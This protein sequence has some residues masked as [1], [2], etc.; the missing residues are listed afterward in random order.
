M[1]PAFL[2]NRGTF[3]QIFTEVGEILNSAH[4]LMQMCGCFFSLGLYCYLFCN[5]FRRRMSTSRSLGMDAIVP[6]MLCSYMDMRLWI[7][8]YPWI[9]TENLWIWIWIW[10]GNFISTATLCILRATARTSATSYRKF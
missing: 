10:V 6:A 2:K 9:S 8:I 4:I 7:W 1:Q 3:M 5:N